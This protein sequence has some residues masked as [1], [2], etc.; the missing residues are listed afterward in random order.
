MGV[1]WVL[2]SYRVPRQPSRLRL[3]IWRRL[4]R[5]GAVAA[6]DSVWILPSDAKTREDFEWIAEEAEERGGSALLW[7]AASFS[8]GQDA[9]LIA[10]FRLAA[11]QRYGEIAA[12]ARALGRLAGRRR[13]TPS[14]R[15]HA[16]RQ[17]RA[18]ERAVRLERRRDCFRAPGRELAERA[19]AE[20]RQRLAP[21]QERPHA[22]GDPTA[23]SR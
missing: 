18:L 12:T 21:P 9:E 7:E 2:L 20:A 11:E 13:L 23:L 10:Q 17:V 16:T 4:Q 22:V 5:L 15:L 1:S 3:T 6:H 8:Q 14:Q 19:L